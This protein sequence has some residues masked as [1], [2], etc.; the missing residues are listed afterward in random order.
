MAAIPDLAA[1]KD[2][3]GSDH[4]W[5]DD[6][7]SATLLAQVG[8]QAAKIRTQDPAEFPDPL[9]HAL[10]R[11]VHVALEL[12]ALPLGMQV[13]VSETNVAQTR[14]MSP[15]KDPVVVDLETPYRKRIP[16]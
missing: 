1:V 2:Y 8:D 7:I 10:C 11:R 15:S 6:Q 16:G 12:K 3:L 14:V 9:A 13:T 4:S 5:S